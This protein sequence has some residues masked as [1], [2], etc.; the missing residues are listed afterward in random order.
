MG[1]EVYLPVGVRGH[2]IFET[3]YGWSGPFGVGA[4]G[5]A[6]YS[7]EGDVH[8]DNVFCTGGKGRFPHQLGDGHPVARP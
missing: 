1:G 7:V 4:A 3:Y 8:L 6:T 5:V 2:Y